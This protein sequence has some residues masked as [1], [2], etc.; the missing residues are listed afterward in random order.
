VQK[1]ELFLLQQGFKLKINY[2]KACNGNNVIKLSENATAKLTKEC[3]IIPVGCAETEG[4]KSANVHYEIF[5][6]NL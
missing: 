6:N 5:K 4:F 1:I 2:I 3:E